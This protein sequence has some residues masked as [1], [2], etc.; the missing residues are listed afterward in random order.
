MRHT[1]IWTGQDCPTENST[2]RETK[3][4]REKNDGKITSESGLAL[5]GTAYCGKLRTVRSEGR[6]L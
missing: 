3:R 4:Q 2:R 6:W 1:I 5:N